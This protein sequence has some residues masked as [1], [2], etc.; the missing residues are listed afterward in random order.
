MNL[1][2]RMWKL[3][4]KECGPACALLIALLLASPSVAQS[5]P[6]PD[7]TEVSLAEGT[8]EGEIDDSDEVRGDAEQEEADYL[9][10]ADT[11]AEESG[12][13]HPDASIE[14]IVVQAS[15][16]EDLLRDA[17]IAATEFSGAD[18]QN[19]RIQ[20]VADLAAYTPNLEINTAFAASNPTLFVRGVGLKDYNSNSAGAVAIYQ[21]EVYINSPAAQLFQLFDIANIE[22][23]RGPQGS[24][25]GRNATAGAIRIHSNEPDGEWS[26]RGSF[27]YGNYNTIEVEGAIGFPIFPEVFKDRLSGRVAGIANFRDGYVENACANWDPAAH[28]GQGRG[29]DTGKLVPYFPTSEESLLKLYHGDPASP[30]PILRRGLEPSDEAVE[31]LRLNGTPYPPTAPDSVRLQYVYH[32]VELYRRLADLPNGASGG[33]YQER[34]LRDGTP[35]G[36]Q[37]TNF[38]VEGDKICILYK[39]GNVRTPNGAANP[40]PLDRRAAGDFRPDNNVLHLEDFQGLKRW[41][42]NVEN[43]A[44]R[45]MLR[46]QPNDDL[47]FLFNAHWG[48]NRGD[49]LHLQ[50]VGA[51]PAGIAEAENVV[52]TEPLGYLEHANDD[53]FYEVATGLEPWE[54][55]DGLAATGDPDS[56][57]VAG[58]DPFKGY[59][60]R[61]G[62]EILDVLGFSLRGTW[63]RDTWRLLSISAYEENQRFVEDEGDDCPC[64][65]LEADYR[66]ESWQ[67]SQEL[68]LEGEADDYSWLVGGYFLYERLKSHNFYFETLNSA[69][70]QNFDQETT[71]WYLVAAGHYDFFEAG[72]RP[73]LYQLSLDAGA[74]YNL[75][76]KSFGL[77][78][79][80]T[81]YGESGRTTLSGAEKKT[82]TGL[83][84]DLTLSYQPIAASRLY[85]KY[86]RGMKAGHFNAGLTVENR[87]NEP[88][89]HGQSLRPVEPEFIHALEFGLKSSLF[90]DRLQLSTAFFR[91]WYQNL[92]IFDI[93]NELFAIP[94]QQLLNSDANILG[95]EVEVVARPIPGLLIEAGFGWLDSELLDFM[96]EKQIRPSSRFG[97]SGTHATFDYSGNPLIAAPRYNLSGVVEYEIPLNRWGSLIPRFD[98]SWRSQAFVDPQAEDLVAQAP[99]ALLNARLAYLTPG[100]RIEVAAWVRNF[101]D[102]KYTIDVFDLTRQYKTLLE[103]WGEPRTFGATFSLLY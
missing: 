37:G 79:I 28:L 71:A 48:Q 73:G 54:F 17:P 7:D 84:G 4:W 40:N 38:S 11:D 21:D 83:T 100:G 55:R 43:W 99:Y 90:D 16:S 78:T 9:E 98:F 77:K 76:H 102:Q 85:A 10:D 81:T 33:S 29:R 52:V 72:E 3:M 51:E 6:D 88:Q 50:A 101:M 96:V 22:V 68:R 91:Y 36:Q 82:W 24:T 34:K 61:D 70:D 87:P 74:R 93:V 57:G 39:P 13:E 60:N 31:V 8:V 5:P 47:D 19:L 62:R 42:N 69:L 46:F 86:T 27:T 15:R 66:D 58:A 56:P 35:V 53:G 103:V 80:F 59:Y 44:L 30:D 94:T 75:E 97:K 2:K 45:G 65:M 63:E 18:L 26:T 23:L 32:N 49:S 14:E 89:K 1:K 12:S 20:N 41:Q 67:F 95:V 92:Q 25:S 64:V